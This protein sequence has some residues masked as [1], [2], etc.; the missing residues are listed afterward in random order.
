MQAAR[1]ARAACFQNEIRK[2]LYHAFFYRGGFNNI[3]DI[4]ARNG[5]HHGRIHS[6][7]F[8]YSRYRHPGEGH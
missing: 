6:R 7:S 3:V 2:D 4:R 5:L 8:G 1:R